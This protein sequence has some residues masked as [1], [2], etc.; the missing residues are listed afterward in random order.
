MQQTSFTIR[1]DGM[2]F[3]S[4]LN[5]SIDIDIDILFWRQS[6]MKRTFLTVRSAPFTELISNLFHIYFKP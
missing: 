1:P 4:I 5:I 6:K 3:G 2:T